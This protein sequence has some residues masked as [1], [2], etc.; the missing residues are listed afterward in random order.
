MTSQSNSY[1]KVTN[2]NMLQNSRISAN[3]KRSYG[4]IFHDYKE[5]QSN[6]KEAMDSGDDDD[7]KFYHD[8]KKQI[9]QDTNSD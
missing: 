8:L 1:I 3:S 4:V 7:I 9:S 2:E 6:L 5:V